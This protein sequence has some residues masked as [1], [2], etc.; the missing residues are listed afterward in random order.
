MSEEFEF[1]SEEE[2]VLEKLRRIFGDKWLERYKTS[3]K[4]RIKLSEAARKDLFN[5]AIERFQES[6]DN[7]KFNWVDPETGRVYEVALIKTGANIDVRES[8]IGNVYVI[9]F[10]M[11]QEPYVLFFSGPDDPDLQL[12]HP[13]SYYIAVVRPRAGGQGSG[14]TVAAIIP[15]EAPE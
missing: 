5:E 1:E 4:M 12:L 6:P 8:K 10:F 3:I 11:E 7:P 14:G 15:L 2:E 9:A 13:N